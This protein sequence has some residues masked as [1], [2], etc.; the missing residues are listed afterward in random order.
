MEKIPKPPQAYKIPFLPITCNP[1]LPNIKKTNPSAYWTLVPWVSW[2]ISWV[3]SFNLPW[4]IILRQWNYRLVS[5]GPSLIIWEK[6]PRFFILDNPV[7]NFV[8]IKYLKLR[9]T[10]FVS[11]RVSLTSW[12]EGASIALVGY[13]LVMVSIKYL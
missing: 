8:T 4:N 10:G 6:M 7:S 1:S 11:T 3:K 12:G 5:S 9:N 2:R 13:P